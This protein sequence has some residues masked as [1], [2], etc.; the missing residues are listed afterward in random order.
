[1]PSASS[2]ES[3]VGAIWPASGSLAA[4]SHSVRGIGVGGEPEPIWAVDD[5]WTLI[6]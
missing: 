5:P 3:A 4:W 2:A 6:N 1:M